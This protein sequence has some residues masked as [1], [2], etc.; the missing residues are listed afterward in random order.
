MNMEFMNSQEKKEKVIMAVMIFVF[1]GEKNLLLLKR[2]DNGQ[3]EPVKGGVKDGEDWHAAG[4][5]ELKEEAG[6]AP[7]SGLK[8]LK[9]VDDEL[10][11]SKGKTKIKGHVSYCRVF[12]VKPTPTLTGDEEGKEHDDYRWINFNNIHKEELFP[13]LANELVKEISDIV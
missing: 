12:G 8:F 7:D 11:T 10:I 4:L 6:F 9:V 3:W 5:R 13:P 2:C 1:D